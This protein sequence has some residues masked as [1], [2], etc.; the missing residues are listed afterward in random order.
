MVSVARVTASGGKVSEAGAAAA[1]KVLK[2]LMRSS[3][4]MESLFSA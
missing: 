4:A 1:E 2:Y 3:K